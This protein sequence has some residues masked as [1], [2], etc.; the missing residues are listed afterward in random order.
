MRRI[1][2]LFFLKRNVDSTEELV[3]YVEK[4]GEELLEALT[5]EMARKA[6]RFAREVGSEIHRMKS[7]TRLKFTRSG[8]LYGK[9]ENKHDIEDVVVRFFARRFPDFVIVLES[10]RGCY[11]CGK[12]FDRVVF[13]DE[14]LKEVVERLD[15]SMI[16]KM[17]LEQIGDL[18][19]IWEEFYNSQ[20]INSRKNLK[21]FGKSIPKKY[22]T[23]ERDNAERTLGCKKLDEFM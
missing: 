10:W 3:E 23:W 17:D 21:L 20:Y 9:L 5:T 8:I 14:E 7:F 6:Y 16:G 13:A 15:K 1:D 11:I 4:E 18:E 22:H 19:K 2:M 12:N